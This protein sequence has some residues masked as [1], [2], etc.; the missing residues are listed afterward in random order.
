MCKNYFCQKNISKYQ[1]TLE[2]SLNL[3]NIKGVLLTDGIYP[4]TVELSLK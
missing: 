3:Q 1:I 4:R 2:P